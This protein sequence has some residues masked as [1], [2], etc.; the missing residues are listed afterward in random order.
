M[1]FEQITPAATL[2]APL[3]D[4][5]VTILG[6]NG[7][8]LNGPTS[9]HLDEGPDFA[10]LNIYR[11]LAGARQLEITREREALVS[12]ENGAAVV[13]WQPTEECPA[14][15]SATYVAFA[16]DMTVDV[17]FAAVA[18]RDFASFE[19]F[20]AN[21]FTP[22][23]T[24]RF[25]VKDNRAHPESEVAWYQTQWYGSHE[26][27]AWVRDDDARAVFCDG[28]WLTGHALNW[29]FGPDYALPLMTQI[30]KVGHSIILMARPGDCLGLSAF[31]SYHNSQY[32]HLF[33]RDVVEGERVS[34][35]VRMV[36]TSET[37]TAA[38]DEL[39]IDLYRTWVAS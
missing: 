28:R 26:D 37:G 16:G 6:A 31:N 33:G 23:Y 29:Q 8:R 35:T 25:A 36:H 38:V 27:T 13:S 12:E 9:F 5:Q 10:W 15:L 1:A 18:E 14:H 32:F 20:I 21:Y 4:W 34:T 19:L 7:L 11:A 3:G 2:Q 39:A 22:Y 30:H 24:P 17:T